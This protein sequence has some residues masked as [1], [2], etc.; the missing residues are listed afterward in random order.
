MENVASE[1]APHRK[2]TV[3]LVDDHPIVRQGLIQLIN[4]TD[5]LSVCGEASTGR[6]ALELLD[7]LV[8]DI[9]IVDIS[10]EDRN[11]IELIKDIT[12][13][14]PRLPCLVLSMYD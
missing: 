8:P 11:G 7:G 4:S 3:L 9:A 6:E 13:R 12:D 1:S 10:L 14:R 2:S 5:D